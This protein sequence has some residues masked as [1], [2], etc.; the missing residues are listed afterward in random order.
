MFFLKATGETFN[1][2][3]DYQN[4]RI[5]LRC[6][7][8]QPLL[9]SKKMNLVECAENDLLMANKCLQQPLGNLLTTISY[10]VQ[11]AELPKSNTLTGSIVTDMSQRLAV[12][13]ATQGDQL[14]VFLLQPDHD[15]VKFVKQKDIV[16]MFDL[17]F[18]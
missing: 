6:A 18:S 5:S 14:L 2:Y 17:N 11:R 15:L 13:L 16:F 7:N 10:C 1:S 12:I 9:F 4:R 8:F 3:Q